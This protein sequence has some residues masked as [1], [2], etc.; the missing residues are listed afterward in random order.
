MKIHYFVHITGTDPG[1]SGIPRVVKNLGRELFWRDDVDLVPVCWS[2]RLNAV[3]H[4]EQKLLDNLARHDGPQFRESAQA[5]E[6]IAP[7]P[8]DWLFFAEVPHL[9]SQDRDYPSVSI[10]EPIGCGRRSGM[11][12]AALLHDI[13]PLTYELGPER[14]RAFA[15]MVQETGDDLRRMQFRV[16]AHALAQTDLVIPVSRTSG[17]L[18]TQWLIRRGHREDAL[19]PIVPI[20]L[21]EEVFGAPRIVPGQH[22]RNETETKE[23]LTVGTVCAHKNQL[24]TMAAFQRLLERRPDLDLRLNVVGSV[25]PDSAVPASLMTKRAKGRIVLRGQ[26][27]D[28]QLERL[29]GQAYASVFVSLAE[30]FGL[31]VAE[32]LWRGKPCISSNEGSLA[33]IAQGGGCLPVDPHSVDDIEAALETLATDEPRYNELLQQI[34]TRQM[35]SWREYAGAIVG[36]LLAYSAEGPAALRTAAR[37]EGDAVPA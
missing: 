19:P 25:A 10:D 27:P 5:R 36:H 6:P 21:P 34:A 31:P 35:K 13:M 24:S 9:S 29:T 16:Y 28:E 7:A 30:G 26:I 37:R 17:E 11:K 8:G 4:A 3:V 12:V 2:D 20:L 23:F 18:L 33:E 22:A 1:I 15:D 32:S 14:R